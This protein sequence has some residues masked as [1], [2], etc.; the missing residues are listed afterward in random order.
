METLDRLGLSVAG[1]HVKFDS[2]PGER[3][4]TVSPERVTELCRAVDTTNV[5]V[6]YLGA[7]CFEDEQA[8]N[9]TATA[10]STL[11]SSLVDDGITLHYHNH[12]QEFQR[13]DGKYAIEILLER[14]DLKLE[15]DTGWAAYAGADPVALLQTYSDRISMVHVKD[16]DSENGTA[17]QLGTGCLDLDRL[18]DYLRDSTVEW[19]IYEHDSPES[20]L[21]VMV[22][23]QHRLAE[24]VR[25]R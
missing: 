4:P 10:L 16:V 24:Q 23:G 12:E 8:V 25:D 21:D 13:I 20:P 11:A 3:S 9:Q 5:V 22:E 1:I 14:T 17:T 15:L 7:A 18:G 6:P 2:L 19:S